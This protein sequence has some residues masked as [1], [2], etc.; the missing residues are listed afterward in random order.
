MF[1]FGRLAIW[2]GLQNNSWIFW[3]CVCPHDWE[4]FQRTS[5][6]DRPSGVGPLGTENLVKAEA[7]FISFWAQLRSLGA[8]TLVKA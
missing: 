4:K 3:L 6:F 5:E 7:D 1:Y 8:E 2:P